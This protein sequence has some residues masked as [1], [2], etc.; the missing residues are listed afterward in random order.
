MVSL[1]TTLRALTLAKSFLGYKETE[2]LQARPKLIWENK[3][4]ETLKILIQLQ[5]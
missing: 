5:K 4:Q 1:Q 2:F 3:L